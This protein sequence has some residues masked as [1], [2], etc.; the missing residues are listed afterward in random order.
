MTGSKFRDDSEFRDIYLFG[1]F[2]IQ[3]WVYLKLAAFK[4]EEEVIP[5]PRPASWQ[6]VTMKDIYRKIDFMVEQNEI[7]ARLQAVAYFFSG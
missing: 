3:M 1:A 5:I 4:T 2:E 6:P 7:D